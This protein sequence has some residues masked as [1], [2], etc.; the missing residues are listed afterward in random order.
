MKIYSVWFDG[1][2][3]SSNDLISSNNSAKLDQSIASGNKGHREDK[4]RF[5][6]TSL[7]S[8]SRVRLQQSNPVNSI[9]QSVF[10]LNFFF[11]TKMEIRSITYV[12]NYILN[13]MTILSLYNFLN[14]FV[15]FSKKSTKQINV[16][17]HATALEYVGAMYL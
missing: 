1:A 3:A 11:K 7:I 4:C 9:I 13:K 2:L 10:F 16:M 12:V 15:P 6:Q 8:N 5:I 14:S 17:S